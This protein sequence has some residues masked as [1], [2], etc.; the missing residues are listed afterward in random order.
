MMVK[1]EAA[2]ELRP[3]TAISLC[4]HCGKPLCE[5]HGWIVAADDAFAT[6]A[7]R[8]AMHCRECAETH[9]RGA[10]KRHG[11]VEPR[12]APAARP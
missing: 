1:C 11:W 8:P 12:P 2:D 3:G 9:H 4:H 6:T 5:E 7:P 10:V